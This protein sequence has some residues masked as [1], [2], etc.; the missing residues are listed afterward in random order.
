MLKYK[1]HLKYALLFCLVFGLCFGLGA[2]VGSFFFPENTT[3]E[4]EETIPIAEKERTNILLLGVDARPGETDNSRSDTIILASIDPEFNRAA[5]ISI[6]RDTKVST[7]GLEGMDKINAANVVGGPELAVTKVEELMGEEIDY[8]IEIDFQGFKN[9]IDTIGGITI[10]VD[11]RM[12]K[13]SENID[14]KPGLQTLNGYDALGYVRFRGYLNGDIDRTAHQQL[15]LKALGQ[16]LLKPSTIVKLPTIIREARAEIETNLSLTDMLK[17][18]TWLPGYSTDSII[19]QTLPGYF[20][21][22]RNADGVLTAS[23]WVAD[24]TIASTL[25]DK[26][27]AGETVPYL[28]TAPAGARTTTAST[29]NKEAAKT[30][31]ERA[32]LPSAGHQTKTL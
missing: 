8:Y 22:T 12:Y 4:T 3:P 21:D 26:L 32:N 19:A 30:D 11:Q 27:L 24:R 14:L 28:V 1:H 10:D 18:A 29:G 16:E 25:L 9:I 7:A 13:P 23:Y 15:F 2:G 6:P 17:M 31:Q 20:A 5:F